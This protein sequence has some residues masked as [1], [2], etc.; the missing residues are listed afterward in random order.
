MT[1]SN[2]FDTI[3]IRDEFQL[4]HRASDS[5]KEGL[6]SD[7][8]EHNDWKVFVHPQGSVYFSNGQIVVDQDVRDSEVLDG[9]QCG[10]SFMGLDSWDSE[11]SERE[12]EVQLNI[13]SKGECN[14]ALF[15]NHSHCIAAY[16]YD[17]ARNEAVRDMDPETLNRRRR[18]Y[19]NFMWTHPAHRRCPARAVPDACDSLA[20][21]YADN[22]ISGAGSVVPF[23]KEE[24]EE[25]LKRVKEFELPCYEN[26]SAKTSFL[27]WLL[28]EICSFRNAEMYGQLT[29]KEFS[30]RRQ[31][32]LTQH[33]AHSNSS[34]RPANFMIPVLHLIINTVFFGIPYS[35]M[36]L[37]KQ[38]FEYRG[39]LAGM[40]ASWETYI[41]RLVREYSHFLLISTVL[42]SATVGFLA[43]PDV[44]RIVEI[45]A[46]VSAFSSLGSIIVGVFAIWRH[47]AKFRTIDSFTYM[48]NVQHNLLGFYGHAMLL[49]L[50]PVLL[51][52]AI[53]TFTISTLA[54]AVD[55]LGG[56]KADWVAI[57]IILVIFICILGMVIAALYT[58]TMIWTYHNDYWWT[59]LGRVV[60]KGFYPRQSKQMGLVV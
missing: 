20:W 57:V 47:Q 55:S 37:V 35:Y 38:S 49:S 36:R 56:N 32:K 23:S 12:I 58:L 30:D 25:L 59:R 6:S 43:V 19:W 24:C 2:T 54:Y 53:I 39:R 33:K 28:R 41:E 18:L 9:I 48:R 46:L 15:V 10:A 45:A 27:S 8:F 14:F 21:F 1:R 4:N 29:R 51:V 7:S 42:L 5:E 34:N 3:A 40:Q 13:N 16:A 22:L 60:K 52:W 44:S 17:K 26:S 31:D 11:G 50:P